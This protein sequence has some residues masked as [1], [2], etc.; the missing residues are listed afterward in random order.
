MGI[1][2][3]VSVALII[4]MTVSSVAF[5]SDYDFDS[6]TMA[7]IKEAFATL[8]SE[9]QKLSEENE[10]LKQGNSSNE[11]ASDSTG[12]TEYKNTK[13]AVIR[14]EP[15]DNSEGVKY[16]S[17]NNILTVDTTQEATEDWIPVILVDRS[18]KEFRGW[19]KNENLELV[20]SSD[21]ELKELQKKIE[22]LKA[23]KKELNAKVKA[24][25]E[26]LEALKN[27]E[28]EVETEPSTEIVG[29]Q[30]TDAA[31]VRMVQEALN[32]AGFDC[33]TPDGQA[34][35]KTRAAL[36][37]YQREKGIN[38]NG[39]ITDELL[40]ALG[41]ADKIE[42]AA[43]LEASKA[44]YSSD[45]SYESLARNPNTYK[46]QKGKFSGK[47]LQVMEGGTGYYSV[48]RLGIGGSYDNVMYIRYD[49]DLL[50]SR[51]LEDDWVTVYGE[52]TGVYTYESVWGNSI[53]IP[54]MDADI[55]ELG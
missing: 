51:I 9:N 4:A 7:D 48:M 32:A 18:G 55:V 40:E 30:Y 27:Q 46:G 39:V 44:Q 36:E 43:K 26:E 34:G 42:E 35:S 1:L 10:S 5:A 50:S 17:A 52:L 33:G 29:L 45:Y 3:K 20:S 28:P 22:S 38:V 21:E 23:D 16:L 31:V 2:K 14:S 8:E 53:T 15:D 25:E 6:M 37:S 19:I 54:S 11:T 47:V 13:L 49:G 41:I 24:L 12:K